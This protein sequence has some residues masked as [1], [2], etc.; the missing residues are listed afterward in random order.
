MSKPKKSG[1][2]SAPVHIAG[3]PK[4]TRQGASKR[5]KHSATPS[6]KATKTYRGQG[7]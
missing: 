7:R 4:K 5:T 1:L 2:G 3:K 6:N